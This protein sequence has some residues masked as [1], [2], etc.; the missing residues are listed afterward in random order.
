MCGLFAADIAGFTRA[1]RDDD[2]RWDLRRAMYGILETAFD[3][4]RMPWKLCTHEDRGDGPLVVVPAEIS[5]LPLISSLPER[6]RDLIQQHNRDVLEPARIQ[7]RVAVHMGPVRHDGEGF[8]GSDFDLLFRMLDVRLLKKMLADSGAEL[9]LITSD[10]VYK[11]VIVRRPSLANPAAFMKVNARVKQTPV[12][13]WIHLPG[14]PPPMLKAR[15][16]AWV[17]LH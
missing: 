7:L 13:G 14:A 1:D 9:A 11:T 10:Y 8:V 17:P 16:A 2:I 3:E 4:C 15:F 6:L 5:A 12:H